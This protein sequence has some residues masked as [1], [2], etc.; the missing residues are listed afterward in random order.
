MIRYI[1]SL[2][3]L[4]FAVAQDLNIEETEKDSIFFESILADTVTDL[5][6]MLIADINRNKI[7]EKYLELD[8]ISESLQLNAP[9]YDRFERK[10]NQDRKSVV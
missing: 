10:N 3:I 6:L 1:I 7:L 5:E 4:S 2:L 8:I 9:K